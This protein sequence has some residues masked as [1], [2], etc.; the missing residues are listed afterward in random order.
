[1]STSAPHALSPAQRYLILSVAFLGW[2]FAGTQM[3]IQPLVSRSSTVALLWPERIQ[4]ELTKD[5]N[6]QVRGWFAYNN[7]SFL[8]G[9]ALGGMVFGALGDRSGRARAMSL[10]ILCYSTFTMSHLLCHSPEMFALSRF[11]AGLGVGGM[12]PNGIALASEALTNM[13]R[14]MLS[15]ILGTS[16]NVGLVLMGVLAYKIDVT[17][18]DWRW[19]MNV[20]GLS[21]PL[22]FIS[23]GLVPESPRWLSEV[24]ARRAQS[25]GAGVTPVREVFGPAL[26]TTTLL[27]I[28]LGTVPLMGGWGSANWM[29]P[30]ADQVHAFSDP[31]AKALTQIARSVGGTLSSFVG[32][33]VASWLG[34]RTSYFAISLGALIVSEFIFCT[35]D[36]LNPYFSTMAFVLGIVGGLYFGWLPLCL[37]ELFPTRVRSTGAGVSFNFGRIG[38]A[39]GIFIS[40]AVASY[41]GS[42][43]GRVGQV[44]SLIYV[45]GL[46]IVFFMPDTSRKNLND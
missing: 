13:S 19:F 45:V 12:W 18:S 38:S 39:L 4:S 37:P 40:G 31:K 6:S 34:R 26:L 15:G 21:L 32:G 33:W 17:P 20:A 41:F 35:L 9:A 43:Y 44:T 28:V 42:D 14:P 22:G 30:W 29:V 2:L 27:G 11:L 8:L 24:A 23:L 1:M 25:D 16:A 7:A 46:V 3:A 36:P 5:E 10:S